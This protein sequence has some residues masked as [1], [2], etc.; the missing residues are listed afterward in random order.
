MHITNFLV[1]SF[2]TT[3]AAMNWN[4]WVADKIQ[5]NDSL[6]DTR[7][8]GLINLIHGIRKD[9]RNCAQ[10][11]VLGLKAQLETAFKDCGIQYDSTMCHLCI[12]HWRN[13]VCLIH[14]MIIYNN[15]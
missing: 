3:M 1:F 5:K 6:S 10:D 4:Q 15:S 7:K 12:R 13:A 2:Q 9:A 11:E 14:I 8:V